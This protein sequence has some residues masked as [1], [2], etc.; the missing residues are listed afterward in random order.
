MYVGYAAWVIGDVEEEP[1]FVE[2]GDEGGVGSRG[3]MRGKWDAACGEELVDLPEGLFAVEG[4]VEVAE[5]GDFAVD[6]WDIGRAHRC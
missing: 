6:S 2:G 5:S 3:G 1:E 4:E